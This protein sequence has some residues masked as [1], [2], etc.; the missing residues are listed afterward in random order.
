MMT[1]PLEN[2][3]SPL[4]N[5]TPPAG[6]VGDEDPRG[7]EC[8]AEESGAGKKYIT[9][10]CIS[11]VMG[12]M[13]VKGAPASDRIQKDYSSRLGG[14]LKRGIL[15]VLD[16]PEL[17]RKLLETQG[18]T[19]C[20]KLAYLKTVSQ[21]IITL[22]QINGWKDF[23]VGEIAYAGFAVRNM[24]RDLNASVKAQKTDSGRVQ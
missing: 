13:R 23:Y 9:K 15:P 16:Q 20:N 14:L 1:S 22:Q 19:T 5:M 2:M 12:K 7:R 18:W 4:E 17:F 10:E 3:T 11:D 24:T 21:W 6:E 8:G